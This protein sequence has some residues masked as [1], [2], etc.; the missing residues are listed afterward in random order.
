MTGSVSVLLLEVDQ[1]TGLPF[2]YLLLLSPYASL[3]SCGVLDRRHDL[4]MPHEH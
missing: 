1:F 2:P 4:I 3:D